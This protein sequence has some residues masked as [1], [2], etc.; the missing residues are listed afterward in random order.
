MLIISPCPS[1]Y[2]AANQSNIIFCLLDKKNYVFIISSFTKRMM[3][4]RIEF[5]FLVYKRKL[6]SAFFF[7]LKC[8]TN[9]MNTKK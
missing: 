4:N 2:M 7:N 8:I 5:F 6:L 3:K 1:H 9:N